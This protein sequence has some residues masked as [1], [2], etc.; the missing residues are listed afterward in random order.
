[1]TLRVQGILVAIGHAQIQISELQVR[2]QSQTFYR[3][4]RNE[5]TVMK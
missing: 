2:L 4:C 3:F 1:M 5:F